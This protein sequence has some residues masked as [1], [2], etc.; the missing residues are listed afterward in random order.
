MCR[1]MDELAVVYVRRVLMSFPH[2]DNKKQRQGW[3][4]APIVIGD[5]PRD[6][7]RGHDTNLDAYPRDMEGETG[8]GNCTRMVTQ[9]MRFHVL[10]A[11]ILTE[12]ERHRS[13]THYIDAK[14]IFAS[15]IYQPSLHSEEA[16]FSH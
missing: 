11:Q 8:F 16:S 9:R 10:E 13:W 12:T 1:R 3:M 6:R 4:L 5:S 7:G 14:N 15:F 2:A